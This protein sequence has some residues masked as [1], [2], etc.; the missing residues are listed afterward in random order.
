MRR[1]ISDHDRLDAF[2]EP[3]Q[4]LREGVGEGVRPSPILCVRCRGIWPVLPQ[5][6]CKLPSNCDVQAVQHPHG[7]AGVRSAS[8]P[9]DRPLACPPLAEGL[10]RPPPLCSCVRGAFLLA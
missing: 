1:A 7:K 2:F 9:P 10:R 5:D 8:L 4:P 3:L 6:G